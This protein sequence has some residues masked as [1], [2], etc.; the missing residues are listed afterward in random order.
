LKSL[1]TVNENSEDF[2]FIAPEIGPD[3]SIPTAWLDVVGSK[4]IMNVAQIE[5]RLMNLAFTGTAPQV[6]DDAKR[7]M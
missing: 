3:K 2:S 1:S 5:I 6:L 7:S 4:I